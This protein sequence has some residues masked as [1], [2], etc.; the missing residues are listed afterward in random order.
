MVEKIRWGKNDTRVMGR[1]PFVI[2][3]GTK[4]SAREAE[5]GPLV[6]ERSVRVANMFM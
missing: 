3:C 2:V 6:E 1:R 4:R 5:K